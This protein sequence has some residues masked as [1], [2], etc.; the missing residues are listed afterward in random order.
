[1]PIHDQGY[2]RY[3]GS[4]AAVGRSWQVITR[5][6]IRTVLAKRAFLGLM[7]LAWSPFVVRAVQVYIAANFS[8]GLV[9]RAEGRDLPRV[10][11]P[12][13]HLRLLRHDLRRRRADRQRSARQRAAGLS[14]EA[15]DARRIRRRQAG[16]SSSCSCRRHLAA[17]DH[18]AARP[19]HVRRQ[20]HLRPR[21]IF[22]LPAITLFSLLQ[23]LV[24]STTMLALSSMSKSAASS[25]SCTRA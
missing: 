4:R 7:L 14:L 9:P 23:V 24:A 18:A 10:S 11:R 20:L 22:L 2:R 19:D 13:G 12:A 16:A 1:M 15:A 21:N 5:A 6:G 8:A 17:G 25:A 3:V